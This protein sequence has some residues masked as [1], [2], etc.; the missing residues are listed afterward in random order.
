MKKRLPIILIILIIAAT[1]VSV[2][3]KRMKE[4]NGAPLLRPVP[5][6]VH[7]VTGRAGRPSHPAAM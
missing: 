6:A 3:V 7:T 2:R 4:K 1:F 5:M